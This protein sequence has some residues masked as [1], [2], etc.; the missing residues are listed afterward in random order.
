PV[1]AIVDWLDPVD[2][3]AQTTACQRGPDARLAASATRLRVPSAL[4]ACRRRVPHRGAAAAPAQN[5]PPG[6][7]P[8]LRAVD[9]VTPY[10]GGAEESQ[11]RSVIPRRHDEGSQCRTVIPRRHDEGS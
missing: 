4:S 9:D 8:P 5:K 6:G 7:V 11:C 3:R 10:R 2:Q 1:Y